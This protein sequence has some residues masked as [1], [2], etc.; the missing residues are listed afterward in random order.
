MSLFHW[1]ADPDATG[2]GV[3]FTS[4]ALDL[5]D[6]QS[7][8]SRAAAFG[9]L[10]DAL[11]VPIAIIDQVH[12]RDVLVVDDVPEGALLDTRHRAD[13]LVSTRPGLAVAVRVADCLPVL[14]A[15]LDGSAVAAAH[16]GRPGLLAGVLPAT[17]AALRQQ[18]RAPLRAWLG[19]HVCGGCYEVPEEMAADAGAC[20]GTPRTR[21]TWGTPSIDLAAGALAQLADL[22]VEVER[23]GECTLHGR[24]LHSHRRGPEA[25]RQVGVVWRAPA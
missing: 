1:F 10:S 25:G 2:V 12:G 9:V 19:P 23:V 8:G 5:G 24:G 7:A 16:A 13:A 20:L 3:A 6:R 18:T 14:F 21:T 11:G 4:D 17:V 15:A 22:G